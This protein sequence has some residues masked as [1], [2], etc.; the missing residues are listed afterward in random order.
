MKQSILIIAALV[1]LAS[2]VWLV[3]LAFK[4]SGLLWAVLIAFFSLIA[5]F[6]FCVV[7]KEGWPA[8]TLNVIAWLTII[9]VY[10][11]WF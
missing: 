11:N 7:K 8:W 9:A 1:L 2:Q 6:I 10:R 4:R 3:V 5:G